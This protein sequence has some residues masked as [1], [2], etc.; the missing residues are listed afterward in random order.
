MTA[1]V[2]EQVVEWQ[3]RAL[4]EIYPI[5]YCDCIAVKV[6]LDKQLINKS[7]F[8]V[9]GA[10]MEG[11]KELLGMWLTEMKGAKF[12]LNVLT[13]LQ[14]CGINNILIACVDGLKGFPDAINTIFS[15]TQIQLRIVH[16]MRNSVKYV[17]WK[18]YKAVT[19]DLKKIYQSIT[20]DESLLA[21]EQFS[22]RWGV[23]ILKSIVLG[24]RIGISSIPCFTT[25][26]I[27]VERFM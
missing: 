15:E 11:Q 12:W 22:D 6:R 19:T 10:N 8:L 7:V 18:D 2:L 24:R 1:S 14:N 13:D 16:M 4:D 17:P 26:R 25:Q 23:I 3:S 9:L 5:V 20:E 27:F 21:L